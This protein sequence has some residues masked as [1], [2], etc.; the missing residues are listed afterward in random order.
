MNDRKIRPFSQQPN[1]E[2]FQQFLRLIYLLVIAVS[3]PFM[4]LYA[5]VTNHPALYKGIGNTYQEETQ[6]IYISSSTL[7]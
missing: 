4:N 7:N 3:L 2:I 5:A 1:R 6:K